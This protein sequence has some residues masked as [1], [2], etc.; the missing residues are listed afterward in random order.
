MLI[1]AHIEKIRRLNNL[2]NSLDPLADF[3]LWFWCLMLGGTNAVNA[4]LHHAGI[5]PEESAFPSQPG[6]FYTFV[7]GKYRPVLKDRGDILH[8]GRPVLA[9][10][11]PEDISAM[12]E[13]MEQI[14]KYRD[15]CVRGATRPSS[16]IVG[17]CV[18]WYSECLDLFKHRFPEF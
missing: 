7:D 14:E 17:Q 5:T 10:P 12:M 1:S 16:A 2:H 13:Q 4:A 9:G 8:V 11:M 18:A 15:P 3:E 6:V